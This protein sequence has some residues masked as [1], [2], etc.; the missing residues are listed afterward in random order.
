MLTVKVG[1]YGICPKANRPLVVVNGKPRLYRAFEITGEGASL[2]YRTGLIAFFPRGR[3][4]GTAS[5]RDSGRMV[6]TFNTKAND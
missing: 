1:P 5:M 6:Y 4:E 3:Y 2:L